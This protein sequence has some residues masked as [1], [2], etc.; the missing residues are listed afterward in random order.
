MSRISGLLALALFLTLSSSA[1]AKDKHKAT[2]PADVLH[3]ETAFVTIHPD[4]GEPLTDLSANRRAREAVE[5]ALTKWG[6]FRVVQDSITADL[7]FTVRTGS[8]QM[9]RPTVKGSPTD[10]RPVT[11]QPSDNGN[12]R[13]GAQHGRP[14]DLS[15]PIPG[16]D[17]SPHVST[18]VGS[19]NDTLEVYRGREE[20]PALDTSPVW[21]YGAK[22]ALHAPTVSA[23]E[24]FQKA[25]AEAEKAAS[26]KPDQ[27]TP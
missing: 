6:R 14:P 21:R 9:V 24:Q 15:Q 19:S 10:D 27:Q 16:Q 4:A 11:V 26:Q 22:D 5:R 7:I 13:I 2:L 12:I 8:G 1:P 23:V 20:Q 17:T 3:A 18:E 25:I